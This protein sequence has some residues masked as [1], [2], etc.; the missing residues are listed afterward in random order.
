MLYPFNGY[1]DTSGTSRVPCHKAADLGPWGRTLHP[2]LGAIFRKGR[3]VVSDWWWWWDSHHLT[4]FL[5]VHIFS[6]FDFYFDPKVYHKKL[7][8]AM[9]YVWSV[10]SVSV[11]SRG[12]A[13]GMEPRLLSSAFKM[14]Q[15]MMGFVPLQV[16]QPWQIHLYI[17]YE[18]SFATS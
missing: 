1:L 9:I 10:H 11:I 3:R 4:L 15:I 2:G 18:Y 5:Y 6:F 13:S 12:G 14:V 7:W 8:I 16:H 17:L